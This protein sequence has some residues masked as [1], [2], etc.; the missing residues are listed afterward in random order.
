MAVGVESLHVEGLRRTVGYVLMSA[1]PLLTRRAACSD[2]AVAQFCQGVHGQVSGC[3]VGPDEGDR[4]G[5]GAGEGTGE[6]AVGE[7]GE[8]AA[9]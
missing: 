4:A 8:R 9:R 7:L 2:G 1:V 5:G 6:A 3:V